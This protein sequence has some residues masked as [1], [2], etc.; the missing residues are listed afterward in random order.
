[1]YDC[2][3]ELAEAVVI[4][5]PTTENFKAAMCPGKK[6]KRFLNNGD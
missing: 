4:T 5:L 6:H 3:F 1:V 2:L